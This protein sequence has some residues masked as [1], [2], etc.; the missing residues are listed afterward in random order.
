M[1]ANLLSSQ[2]WGLGITSKKTANEQYIIIT[3]GAS[4]KIAFRYLVRLILLCNTRTSLTNFYK[5]PRSLKRS[6]QLN[7][8]T[9]TVGVVHLILHV[10]ENITLIVKYFYAATRPLSSSA[11]GCWEQRN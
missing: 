7:Q 8:I 3:Q 4:L 11:V 10:L 2:L 6:I 1:D 5:N 9:S